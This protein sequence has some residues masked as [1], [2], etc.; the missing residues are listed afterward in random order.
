MCV[1]MIRVRYKN[2]SDD[3]IVECETEEDASAKCYLLNDN[4]QVV[5]YTIFK[6]QEKFER[7]SVMKQVES[8]GN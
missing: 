2:E 4:E 6:R 5:S 1:T 8:N 3:N 7:V